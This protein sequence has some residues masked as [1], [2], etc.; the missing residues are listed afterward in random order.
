M[1]IL[2]FF[3]KHIPSFEDEF[4]QSESEQAVENAP[5]SSRRRGSRVATHIICPAEEH[6]GTPSAYPYGLN[7]DVYGLTSNDDN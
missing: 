1:S 7:F 5:A 6:K 3:K 2:N 4:V